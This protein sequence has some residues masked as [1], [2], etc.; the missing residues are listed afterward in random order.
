MAECVSGNGSSSL[1]EQVLIKIE[2]QW[3]FII[4]ERGK[5]ALGERQ[6]NVW[7]KEELHN[8]ILTCNG[9][10]WSEGESQVVVT[11][12]ALPNPPQCD[13]IVAKCVT[14]SET[15]SKPGGTRNAIKPAKSPLL[16]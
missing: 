4:F 9:N 11:S 6:G 12:R 3:L 2:V 13:G 14:F 15:P 5:G 10:R 7:K 8:R 16:L 1:H